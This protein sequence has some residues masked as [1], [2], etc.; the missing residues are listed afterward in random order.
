MQGS[1]A[2]ALPCYLWN[3]ADRNPISILFP[4]QIVI[5]MGCLPPSAWTKAGINSVTTERTKDPRSLGNIR[6]PSVPNPVT[7]A[8]P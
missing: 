2:V 7:P 3:N 1:H 6:H 4:R 8:S 5:G